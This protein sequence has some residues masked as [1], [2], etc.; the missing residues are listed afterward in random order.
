M[1]IINQKKVDKKYPLYK[2]KAVHGGFRYAQPVM[3]SDRHDITELNISECLCVIKKLLD[4]D[5]WLVIVTKPRWRVIPLMCET[6]RDYQRHII[7]RFT[8]GSVND[9][10]LKFWEPGASGFSERLACL[11]Y[12]YKCGYHTSVSCEPY[13]DGFVEHIYLATAEFVDESFWIGTLRNF[14]SRV[15]V[16]NMSSDEYR[17]FVEPLLAASKPEVVRAIYDSMKN[18]P[19]VRWKDSIRK[20]IPEAINP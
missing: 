9:E 2:D 1:P 5:N 19:L 16:E 4:K 6:L 10:V 8:I 17:R 3:F 15:N 11:Q 20:I 18:K 14:D 13:L 12:A 7:F